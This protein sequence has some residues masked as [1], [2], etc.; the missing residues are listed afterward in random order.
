MKL[1]IPKNTGTSN[2]VVGLNRR[3]LSVTTDKNGDFNI[4]TRGDNMIHK[5]LI[6][7]YVLNLS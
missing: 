3:F 4:K 7:Q 1:K 5:I 6:L 2:I